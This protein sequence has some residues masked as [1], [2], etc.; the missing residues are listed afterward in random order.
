MQNPSIIKLRRPQARISNTG[1][2]TLVQSVNKMPKMTVQCVT[3]LAEFESL[4]TEWEAIPE[5]NPM[6][7]WSWQRSWLTGFGSNCKLAVLVARQ[8]DRI[9][10]ILPQVSEHHWVAGKQLILIGSKRACSDNLSALVYPEHTTEVAIKFA[11]WLV[12]AAQRGFWNRLNYDGVRPDNIF[13]QSLNNAFLE[14]GII[15]ESK[16]APHCWAIPLPENFEMYL[17]G[18]SKR[19]RKLLKDLDRDFVASQRATLKTVITNPY[20]GECLAVVEQMHQRRW[21]GQGIQGC[22]S[23]TDFN[24]FLN[25]AVVRMCGSTDEIEVSLSI[26]DDE[27]VAGAIALRGKSEYFVYLV[28]MNPD[29]QE[30]RPGWLLNLQLIHRAM[31]LGCTSLNLLRGD[32]AYKQRLGAV[33]FEQF[34]WVAVAPSWLP[35]IRHFIY[36]TGANMRHWWAKKSTTLPQLTEH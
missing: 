33:G 4:R 19:A 26:V 8:D 5:S 6:L 14:R 13:M 11:D 3:T 22:F 29:A 36:G 9:I 15:F 34:R 2:D 10:G 28:G 35:H 24:V 30:L 16:P 21:K 7:R 31:Q 23:D 27:P 20:A 18:L 1:L 12:D 25:D 32:E 17:K